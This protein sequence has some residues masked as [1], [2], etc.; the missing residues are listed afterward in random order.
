MQEF[1]APPFGG[2]LGYE[3][4][5][6]AE[7]IADG[8]CG[9]ERLSG[10]TTGLASPVRVLPRTRGPEKRDGHPRIAREWPSV[11]HASDPEGRG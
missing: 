5:R 6:Y 2:R 4:G 1:F 11:L 3:A 9:G 10:S 7:A 8:A